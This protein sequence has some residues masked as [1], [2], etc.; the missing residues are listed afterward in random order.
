MGSGKTLWKLLAVLVVL[1]GLLAG[2]YFFLEDFSAAKVREVAGRYSNVVRFDFERAII[3]PFDRTFHIWGVH[4]DFAVGSS[5]SADEIVIEK[6][7]REHDVPLFF[8]GSVKNVSVP[9]DFMN[10]GSYASEIRKLGYESLNFDLEADYIYEDRTRR[11]SV[12]NLG[13]D[14]S[15]I[16][17]ISAGFDLGDMKLQSPGLSGMIGVSMLDGGLV[18]HDHSLTGRVL[19][20]SAS[21]EKL[22]IGEIKARL[23]ERLQL[24]IQEA[25]S[26]GNG[27]AENFYAG[28]QKF[29]DNPGKLVFRVDPEEPVPLLYLFMGRDFEELLGIYGVTVE[30]E[31]L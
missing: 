10:F 3:N 15:D 29:I 22:G 7:D 20:L 25:R 5:L 19:E 24:R 1:S 4:C 12:K 31:N 16:C 17:R 23:R 21:D 30:A 6:F 13:F 8:K 2:G 26:L 9:V 14:G 28:L 11:L 18:Y 27:Y